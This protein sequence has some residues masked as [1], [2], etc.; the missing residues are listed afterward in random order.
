MISPFYLS[1]S[2][3]TLYFI[4]LTVVGTFVL[5]DFFIA[6]LLNEFN[7]AHIEEEAARKI[8]HSERKVEILDSRGGARTWTKRLD[9]AREAASDLLCACDNAKAKLALLDA[10]KELRTV[11]EN[12][13]I[14]QEAKE[15]HRKHQLAGHFDTAV[16]HHLPADHPQAIVHEVELAEQGAA[17]LKSKAETDGRAEKQLIRA[18]IAAEGGAGR[19]EDDG[20]D[21]SILGD[22]LYHGP[23]KINLGPRTSLCCIPPG[24][25]YDGFMLRRYLALFLERSLG[26]L[27]CMRIRVGQ[28]V[29]AQVWRRSGS[30]KM[31]VTGHVKE[32]HA[33]SDTFDVQLHT[34]EEGP[35][36]V[37]WDI[38]RE[39]LR[40][41]SI[42]FARVLRLVSVENFILL[43]ILFS[44]LLLAIESPMWNPS[45]DRSLYFRYIEF[46]INTIFTVESIVK[47]VTCVTRARARVV[48]F[49]LPLHL[50][51]S[52]SQFDSLP[53]TSSPASLYRPLLLPPAR[54][55][56]ASLA[57][58]CTFR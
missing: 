25:P 7:V 50:R 30:R 46:V 2:E 3:A 11:V 1:R 14:L 16:E 57:T 56:S 32:I 19:D 20:T 51:D 34:T 28:P 23:V 35:G 33:D 53:L 29:Q 52:C 36:R 24:P 49:Y 18:I 40:S 15:Y 38:D 4:S 13:R 41:C 5:L 10:K 9:D 27:Q 45:S 48:F 21:L 22:G 44:S 17:A 6:I 54:S 31:W 43:T 39:D 58:Y 55:R 42:V 8:A 12:R 37:Y 26:E 47:I